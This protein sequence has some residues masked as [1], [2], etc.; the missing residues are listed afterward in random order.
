MDAFEVEAVDYL[1]KPYD[2]TRFRRTMNRIRKSMAN[3]KKRVKQRKKRQKRLF[4]R[5]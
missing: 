3:R 2:E 4:P 5:C 1:L